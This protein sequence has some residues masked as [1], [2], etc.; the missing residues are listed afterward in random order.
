MWNPSC[1][2]VF[3][4]ALTKKHKQGK[5]PAKTK[6]RISRK[7][8][9]QY[10]KT[11]FGKRL[12]KPRVTASW[13]ANNKSVLTPPPKDH[14][15]HQTKTW[16][17]P[18]LEPNKNLNHLGEY[19]LSPTTFLK[20]GAWIHLQ[21]SPRSFWG[22]DSFTPKPPW[23]MIQHVIGSWGTRICSSWRVVFTLD[24]LVVWRL[25]SQLLGLQKISSENLVDQRLS[26]GK[27]IILMTKEFTT[28]QQPWC[29]CVPAQKGQG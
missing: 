11:G 27:F 3:L 22:L 20:L 23:T 1:G 19:N 8:W 2:Y 16:S 12:W 6:R 17:V 26:M 18:L 4:M 14:H 5:F 9:W 28:P 24:R 21:I 29:P 13:F 25:R 15:H 10:I 7:P